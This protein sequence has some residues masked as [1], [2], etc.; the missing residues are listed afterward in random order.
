VLGVVVAF[1]V[2]CRT[3]GHHLGMTWDEQVDQRIVKALLRHPIYGSGLD[4]TQMRLPM[5]VGAAVYRLTGPSLGVGRS[6]SVVIGA[7]TILAT[8]GLARRLF[9]G[10]TACI[11]AATVG[12]SPY[13]LGFARIAMTEGDI[14]P[15]LFLTLACWAVVRYAAGPNGPN[16]ALAGVA[17]GLAIGAKLYSI[18]LIPAIVVCEMLRDVETRRR[19]VAGGGDEA[20]GRWAMALGA[21]C[22]GLIPAACVLSQLRQVAMS[23]VAWGVLAAATVGLL[24]YLVLGCRGWRPGLWGG[25][26]TLCAVAGAVAC[27]AMPEHVVQPGILRELMRRT[28]HWD[29]RLPGSLWLDHVRLYS[30]I[31]LIK[32]T[33]PVGVVTVLALVYAWVRQGDRPA[34]RLPIWGVSFFVVSVCTLPLRQT[35]YLMSIFPLIAIITADAVMSFRRW[36]A[37]RS[38]RAGVVCS[39][40]MVGLVLQLGWTAWRVWPDYN[41]YGR[42]LIGDRWLGAEARGYRNLIQIP[43]DGYAE[44]VDWCRR[45]VR[46]GQRVVS[47]LW[48]DHVL[49]ELLTGAEPFEI[50]RRG[51]YAAA[52]QHRPVSGPPSLEGADFLLLHVSNFAEYGDAPPTGVLR[53]MFDAV[54]V[55]SVYRDGDFLMA[56]VYRRKPVR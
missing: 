48:A 21:V 56:S 53:E 17:L 46:P 31:L 24:A 36:V 25:L 10:W 55:F 3:S 7:L 16:L 1:C 6:I 18:F 19:R 41:L 27:A 14:Y 29:Y 42:R 34:L 43:C 28:A 47:Y 5:Y 8:F 50:V 26:F 20:S 54:P 51:V 49:D 45:N 37:A 9:D 35:F 33:V 44:L 39:A 22:L 30:G 52:E 32:S 15:A 4:G 40:A 23:I 38:S 13:F 11:A 2:L 12:L